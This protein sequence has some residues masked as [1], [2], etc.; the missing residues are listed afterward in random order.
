MG[1]K[2]IKSPPVLGDLG[3]ISLL[4]K[5]NSYFNLATPK[6]KCPTDSSISLE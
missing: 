4:R 3:G 2:I 6:L 1:E 5:I